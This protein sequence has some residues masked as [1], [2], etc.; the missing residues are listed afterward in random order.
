MT[1]RDGDFREWPVVELSRE[2]ASWEV[3]PSM[4]VLVSDFLTWQTTSRKFDVA[5]IV[6]RSSRGKLSRLLGRDSRILPQVVIDVKQAETYRQLL[7]RESL[8]GWGLLLLTHSAV[9][10][11]ET[12]FKDRGCERATGG[13][14]AHNFRDLRGFTVDYNLNDASAV[15]G[16]LGG[17]AICYFGHDAD[18]IYLLNPVLNSG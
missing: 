13:S 7:I 4:E 14:V 8:R 18:P 10:E 5:I 3:L 1:S 6:G 2:H 12:F 11:M 17:R 16:K 15:V 9:H